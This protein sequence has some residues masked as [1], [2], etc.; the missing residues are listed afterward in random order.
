MTG[1]SIN[2]WNTYGQFD[3]ATL[4]ALHADLPSGA[5]TTAQRLASNHP[6]TTA[7]ALTLPDDAD[8]LST[9]IS[10]TDIII[11][12]LPYV[13]H[14]TIIQ[15]AITHH[16]PVVT[17][18]YIS[19]SLWALHDQARAAGITVLNEIGLGPG[20]DHLYAM[21]TI[22]EVHSS[23]GKVRSF[24][25]WCGAVPAPENADNPLG[26]KFSWSP[27][28]VLLALLNEGRW[29]WE[30][31]VGVRE[32]EL[33]R[34]ARVVDVD[35]F[36]LGEVLQGVEMVGLPNRNATGFRDFYGIPEARDVFRGTLRYKG[37]PGVVGA[38]VEIGYFGIEEI[39]VLRDDDEGISWL[40]LTGLLVGICME[41]RTDEVVRDAVVRTVACFIDDE[42]EVERVVKGLEWIGLFDAETVVDGRGT[43][44]DTL[45]ALLERRMAYEPGER[46]MIILQH[47]F[48]I[49][50]A[51]GSME[52]RTSTLVEYGEPL[53]EES[54]SAI[55][56]LVGLPCAVG[57]LAVLEGRISQKGM[58]AP[59]STPEIAALLREE[60]KGQFGIE[61]E[62]R[63]VG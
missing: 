14:P 20:I 29:Y 30:N 1:N 2:F 5:L 38:L 39:P 9:A 47:V 54:R 37:F 46:D 45:C 51:D 44:L 13:Y 50:R 63:V 22:H 49:E 48:G 28:G 3:A 16:K 8:V 19:P 41:E 32:R 15:A 61:L 24:E 34:S 59:W 23:G 10:N 11:S 33:M 58:V 36:G 57:V 40:E 55:A 17:T 4:R 43:P 31:K 21:K 7:V 60:L 56:K 42:E 27:R 18:S 62:E 25:S 53:A 26:Y 35:G 6:N 52:K 12:L